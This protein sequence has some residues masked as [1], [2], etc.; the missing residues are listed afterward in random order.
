MQTDLILKTLNISNT[1]FQIYKALN[2]F[3][4]QT[5]LQL[6]QSLNAPRSTIHSN[7]EKLLEKEIIKKQLFQNRW[8]FVAVDPAVFEKMLNYQLL[9][10]QDKK[11]KLASLKTFLPEFVSSFELSYFE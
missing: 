4:P 7:V 2:K 10:L 9:E 6:S 5:V 8:K 11:E 3:G 1:E